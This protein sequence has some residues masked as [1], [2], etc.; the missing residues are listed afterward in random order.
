MERTLVDIARERRGEVPR[1]EDVEEM[2]ELSR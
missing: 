2:I 1:G